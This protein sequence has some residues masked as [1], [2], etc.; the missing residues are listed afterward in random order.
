MKNSA[1][2]E[3]KIKRLISKR[4][5]A[6]PAGRTDHITM[7]IEGIL[8][9]DTTPAKASSAMS[10]LNEEFVDFNELRVSPIRDIVD[11]L[12]EGFPGVRAKANCMIGALQ[13][14]FD[15]TNDLCLDFLAKKT[16]R[17]IRS[18]LR[19]KIGLSLY[20]ESFLTLFGFS[21]HAMPVDNLLLEALKLDGHIHPD[22]DLP[23]LQGFLERIT[24]GKDA[25]SWHEALRDYAVG[26]AA[27]VARERARRRRQ[28]EAK[29]K[30]EAKA[31]AKEE[32]KAKAKAEAMVKTKVRTGKKLKTKTKVKAP[33][34][35]KTVTKKKARTSARKTTGKKTVKSR[36]REDSITPKRK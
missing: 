9:E 27:K 30:E 11:V 7:L 21:G 5:K 18:V 23:D 35:R 15:Q 28:A 20:A 17:E 14:I 4:V 1:K 33:Q 29:A 13:T 2:Y 16:K 19:E 12:G 24:P 34:R 36:R 32:A 25:M 31:K 26:A 3:K 10:A 6:S 22:S 8:S